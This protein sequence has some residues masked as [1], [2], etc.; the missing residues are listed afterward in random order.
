MV[1]Y[2]R[3]LITTALLPITQ[4]ERMQLLEDCHCY[5]INR[6]ALDRFVLDLVNIVDNEWLKK[7]WKDSVKGRPGA[8][9][10]AAC[11]GLAIDQGVESLYSHMMG[12]DDNFDFKLMLELAAKAQHVYLV[13]PLLLAG[14][15]PERVIQYFEERFKKNI[16]EQAIEKYYFYFA[17]FGTLSEKS[18][19]TWIETC[20]Q[21]LCYLCRLALYEPIYK[22]A[23]ELGINFDIDISYT[24]SR[25]MMRSLRHFE[26]LSRSKHYKAMAESRHWAKVAMAASDKYQKSKQSNISSFLGQFQLSLFEATDDMID[27]HEGDDTE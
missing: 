15:E 13:V 11:L 1:P 4:D 7:Y 12:K 25:I 26:N 22:V 18:I 17:Q 16:P 23:D 5:G 24:Y 8:Y 27:V 20:P 6:L 19:K 10:E 2:H 3:F 9:P 21:R 14:S